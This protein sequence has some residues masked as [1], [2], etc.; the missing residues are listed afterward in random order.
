MTAFP[1]APAPFAGNARRVPAGNAFDWLRQGWATFAAAP[2]PWAGSTF[3]LAFCGLLLGGAGLPGR[4]A[5]PLLAPGIVAGLL[6]ACRV[7]AG[8][9]APVRAQA[10]TFTAGDLLAGFRHAAGPLLGLGLVLLAGSGA[11]VFAVGLTVAGSATHG[12]L[13]AGEGHPLLALGFGL[14]GFVLG[15]LLAL[16]LAVPLGMAFLFA[17]ALSAFHGMPPQAALRASFA[18][19]AGN[20]LP[21]AVA[22][23]LAGCL[24]LLAAVPMGLGF[25]VLVPVLCG[26][27]HAAYRDLFVS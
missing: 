21:L 20:A 22:A 3:A 15:G 6:N 10:A 9:V 19:C 26:A 5:L 18:A 12:A 8:S 25:L 23:L 11:I 13:T 1:L 16:G 17:P 27:L 2:A 4:L 7:L 14:G 24:A